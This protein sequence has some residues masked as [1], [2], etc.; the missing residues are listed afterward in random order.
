MKMIEMMHVMTLSIINHKDSNYISK[1]KNDD[2]DDS[3][4]VT[5]RG[6]GGWRLM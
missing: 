4:N 2:I 3:N 6:E 5:T 1:N